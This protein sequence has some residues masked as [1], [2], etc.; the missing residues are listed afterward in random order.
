VL[1]QLLLHFLQKKTLFPQESSINFANS[2]AN[3]FFLS[4]SAQTF[5]HQERLLAP[6]YF[7]TQQQR[8]F[9]LAMGLP[10]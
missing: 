2:A 7:A 1:F 8:I 10:I 4:F 3:G 5:R 6:K 9:D